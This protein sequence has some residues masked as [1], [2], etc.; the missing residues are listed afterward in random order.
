MM[1]YKEIPNGPY[2][3]NKESH[4]IVITYWWG[5]TKINKNYQRPCPNIDNPIIVKEGITYDE[6]IKRWS[7]NL[8]KLKINHYSVEIPEFVGKTQMAINYKPQFILNCL[9]KFSNLNVVYVDGDIFVHKYP[10][11]F[12]LTN[13]DFMAHGWDDGDPRLSKRICWDPFIT[14]ISGGLIFVGNTFP[15]RKILNLWIAEN[16]KKSNVGKADDRIF[17]FM[18][19]KKNAKLWANIFELPKEF[20]WL[21]FWFKDLMK[22]WKIKKSDIVI[23]HPECLTSEEI[24]NLE[25]Q[26]S[27]NRYPVAYK[28]YVESHITCLDKNP[29]GGEK[30]LNIEY[31]YLDSENQSNQIKNINL[32]KE[33][34][35]YQ[36]LIRFKD[37]WGQLGSRI[38]KSKKIKYNL[39]KVNKPTINY[40]IAYNESDHLDYY[41]L[42]NLS[43]PNVILNLTHKY[44]RF[45]FVP[46]LSKYIKK[47]LKYSLEDYTEFSCG[48]NN[49]SKERFKTDYL[50]K[51][52]SNKPVYFS[53]KTG[54]KYVLNFLLL[55]SINK[56][57]SIEEQYKSLQYTFNSSIQPLQFLRTQ[58]I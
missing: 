19:N 27:K 47:L 3:L 32:A 51:I 1:L 24:A 31:T 45:I 35:K 23:E 10:Y 56:L 39:V 57:T 38:E 2:I 14:E 53:L 18:A 30:F 12:E 21:T 29:L 42:D 55:W 46:K 13:V 22:T 44:K 54:N 33:K 36:D 58:W 43:I 48:N 11:M 26:A 37:A 34:H 28:K 41:A 7:L 4:F 5:K 8:T 9:N 40:L 50:L 49:N 16:K 15:A 17:S 25:G 20:L 52:D 6:M